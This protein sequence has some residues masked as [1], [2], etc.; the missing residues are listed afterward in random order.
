M[1]PEPRIFYRDPSTATVEWQSVERKPGS[2]SYTPHGSYVFGSGREDSA[3]T[4][5]KITLKDLPASWTC[6][7]QFEPTL[8]TIPQ[9]NRHEPQYTFTTPAGKQTKLYARLPMIALIFANVVDD[10][11]TRPTDPLQPLISS[12]EIDRIKSQL[13]DAVRFYWIHSGMKLFL[14]L[15]PLVVQ[16]ML[17]RSNLYGDEWWYPPRDS[18]LKHYLTLSGKDIKNYSGILYLTCTQQYDTTL[19]KYLLAGKGGAF[20]NGVGTGKGYG[21]S[22]WDVTKPNHNAG[23]NWLMVHEFNH[24]L[25]DIFLASGYP[26]YWFN[27]ISPTIGTAATFGEHFDANAYILHIVPP[28]EWYNLKHT[29]LKTTRDADMDGIPDNDPSLPL[30]EVRLGSDSTKTDSDGDGVSDFDELS[31][32]TWISEGWGET[33]GGH[34]IFPALYRTDTDGDGIDDRN[35][36][37]PCYHVNPE[38]H[39]LQSAGSQ[40]LR[41]FAALHDSHINASIFTAWDDSSLHFQFVTDR[42]VPIKLMLDAGADGWFL[43]RGNFLIMVTPVGDSN[44]QAQVQIFNAT[45]PHKWP[46]MDES[47]TNSIHLQ[48][49]LRREGQSFVTNLSI[50][51][52]T[53]LGLTTTEGTAIGILIGFQC[54]FDEDGTK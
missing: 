21:I 39:R 4:L 38:V 14:D 32:S 18:V 27:H 13:A 34:A 33:Y 6:H 37:Y 47:L 52:N 5:H 36:P 1:D 9:R 11:N 8:E 23:N 22:W 41:P 28:E 30:D 40:L 3:S 7:F 10:K 12:S 43:G 19:K 2:V 50:S 31:L 44:V 16:E 42:N 15:E 45:D 26:E 51:R 49:S 17:K 29:D 53:F 54:V 24:Q 46:F 25:D 20:T 48:S 35:D